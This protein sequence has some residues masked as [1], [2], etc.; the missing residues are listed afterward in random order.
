MTIKVEGIQIDYKKNPEMRETAIIKWE[1]DPLCLHRLLYA[2][3]TIN[4]CEMSIC[5]LVNPICA[6]NKELNLIS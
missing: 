6:T 4:I 1:N 5:V 3:L 2:R